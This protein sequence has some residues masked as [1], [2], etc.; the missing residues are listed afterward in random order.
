MQGVLPKAGGCGS[1]GGELRWSSNLEEDSIEIDAPETRLLRL[2]EV[3]ARTAQ[4]DQSE[5][6]A[7]HLGRLLGSRMDA[8]VMME[9][10]RCDGIDLPIVNDAGYC[11]ACASDEG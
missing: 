6:E 9:F 1:I 11:S 8:R 5:Q 10:K 7:A 2:R 3:Q 4:A